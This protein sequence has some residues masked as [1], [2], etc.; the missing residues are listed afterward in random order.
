MILK[1]NIINYKVLNLTEFYNFDIKFVYLIFFEKNDF[2]CATS[3]FSVLPK[4]I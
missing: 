4:S 2:L 1:E 3:I